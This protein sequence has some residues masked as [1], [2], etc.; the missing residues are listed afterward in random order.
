MKKLLFLVLLSGFLSPVWAQNIQINHFIVKEN[1]LK[2]GKLAVIVTDTLDRPTGQI[3]GHYTFSINGF[4]QMLE[5]TDGVAVVPLTIE[6]STFVYIKHKNEEGTHSQL[7]YAYKKAGNIT[8]YPINSWWLIVIP[9]VIIV[10]I[11][12]FRKFIIVGIVLLLI[13]AYFNY[14]NGLSIG[15]FFESVFDWLKGLI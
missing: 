12:A 6:Q 15:T 8:P 13:F 4:S 2:D 11:L 9:L 7:V 1:L 10:L 3:N 14:S 5:F